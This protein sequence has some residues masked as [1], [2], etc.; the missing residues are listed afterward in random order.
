MFKNNKPLGV[1]QPLGGSG[2]TLVYCAH[3]D[4]GEGLV[5]VPL[6]GVDA[7]RDGEVLSTE[8]SVIIDDFHGFIFNK[9]L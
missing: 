7:A 8:V 3:L 6:E 4:P 9:N 5:G 2:R 1:C